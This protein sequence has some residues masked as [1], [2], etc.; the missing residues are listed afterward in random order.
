MDERK[1]DEMR[2]LGIPTYFIMLPLRTLTALN[3]RTRT[4]TLGSNF[5]ARSPR[6]QRVIRRK[7]F[8]VVIATRDRPLRS[9]LGASPGPDIIDISQARTWK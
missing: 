5:Q 1:W 2:S 4:G 8:L 9:C 7:K 3:P 6:R